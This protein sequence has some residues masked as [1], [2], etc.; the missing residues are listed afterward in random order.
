MTA[1]EYFLSVVS[2]KVGHPVS[3]PV[4]FETAVSGCNDTLTVGGEI[5]AQGA[6]ARNLWALVPET[7]AVYFD[8]A[9]KDI[10]DMEDVAMPVLDTPESYIFDPARD[11]GKWVPPSSLEKAAIFLAQKKEE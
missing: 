7:G 3:G 10:E 4:T 1:M 2:E 6:N 9:T 8:C 5:V 11:Y